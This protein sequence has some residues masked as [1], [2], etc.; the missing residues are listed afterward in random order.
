MI[1]RRK[2]ICAALLGL[3]AFWNMAAAVMIEGY[4]QSGNI[5]TVLV[6][7]NGSL[8]VHS[9]LTPQ[10]GNLDFTRVTI[11][12]TTPTLIEDQVFVSSISFRYQS[13]IRNESI[14]T[15]VQLSTWTGGFSDGNFFQFPINS[16]FS[17]DQPA[18]YEG[19]LYALGVSSGAVLDIAQCFY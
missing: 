5:K 17:P 12:S 1:K 15:E 7:P 8:Y 3:M 18:S 14:S 9:T 19:P 13:F 6:N 4:T 16:T 2:S 11:S 10:C